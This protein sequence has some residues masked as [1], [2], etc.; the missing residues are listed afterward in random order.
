MH[1]ELR[2]TNVRKDENVLIDLIISSF[3]GLR[4]GNVAP[5]GELARMVAYPQEAARMEG[6]DGWRDVDFDLLATPGGT[7]QAALSVMP[8]PMW[9]FYL[10]AWLIATLRHGPEAL[11]LY[12]ATVGTLVPS[13]SAMMDGDEMFEERRGALS[14]EEKAAVRAF[15]STL[16]ADPEFEKLM[17]AGLASEVTAAWAGD[18]EPADPKS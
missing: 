16:A 17:G 18:H 6:V 5:L 2:G 3:R 9:A 15:V 10:P 13:L 14:R 12:S 1:D 8:P 11:E 7:V 4:P